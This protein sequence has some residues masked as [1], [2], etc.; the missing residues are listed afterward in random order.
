[1][2][3]GKLWLE[4]RDQGGT[5]TR[6]IA[7]PYDG[8]PVAECA[9]ADA[10]HINRALDFALQRAAALAAVPIYRRA[11]TL[12][13]VAQL[14]EQRAEQMAQLI[15]AEAGKPI[16]QARGEA[17]RGVET[18]VCAAAE[19]R[20]MDGEALPLDSLPR[21]EGRFGIV[22]RFPVGVVAAI[23]PFNF[24]LNLVAHK[25]APAMAAGCPVVLKPASQTPL[26]ALLL[27]HICAEAGL[28]EG[29]LQ[30]LPCNRAEADLLVTDPRPQLL[31]FT[32][33]PQVGWDMKA[34][35]GRKKVVLE[36]GGNAAVLIMPDA[37]PLAVLPALASGAFAYA[38]QVCIS[39]QRIIV[40]AAS[41]SRFEEAFAAHVTKNVRSGNPTDA[42]VVNGPMIDAA[43]VSRI[44]GWVKEARDAGAQVLCGG[45]ANG[46]VVDPAVLTQV[47]PESR[48][49]SDEAFGPVVVV[50]G[51]QDVDQALA[52][53][54]RGRFG[55]QAGVFTQ[56]ISLLWKCLERLEVG[57]V[58][59]NDVPTFRVDQMPYGGVKDSGLGR[60]GIRYALEDMTE[61]RLLVLR[62]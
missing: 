26:S 35:A 25:V 37:D 2:E 23:S 51:Y 50:E 39:V 19:A 59:H 41:Q 31:S 34:R 1:M 6:T 52:L 33:S 5:Q 17:T 44:T 24:P 46:S 18:F 10:G 8:A 53:V 43:N 47:S 12:Q 4:G 28:P 58:I 45:D 13:K 27:A 57:G 22:R 55:L 49:Y 14:L 32:G 62:P 20:R 61:R 15:C 56:D 16:S 30:V 48:V 54:N 3:A 40:P 7:Q 42:A 29:G 36:L 60:E 21:G 11:D 38:G 9:F